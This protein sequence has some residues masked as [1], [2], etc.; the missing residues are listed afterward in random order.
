MKMVAWL[1]FQYELGEIEF[2][3]S[4]DDGFEHSM[5]VEL[6]VTWEARHA[7]PRAWLDGTVFV[8]RVEA[9]LDQRHEGVSFGVVVEGGVPIESTK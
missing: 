4:G 1:S 7:D 9:I 3:P 5:M 2:L 8:K 6:E